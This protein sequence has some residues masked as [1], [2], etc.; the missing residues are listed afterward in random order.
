MEPG[1][2]RLTIDQLSRRTGVT[3]RNI[4]AYQTKGLLPAP[5][6]EGRVGVY[7]EGHMARLKLIASLQEKGY[8]LA[9]IGELLTAWET[10]Q[11]LGALL[12]FEEVLTTPWSDEEP[13]V[14]SPAAV[15]ELFPGLTTD[16]SLISAAEDAGLLAP[17]GQ[18]YLAPSRR[19][20][21]LG[22]ILVNTGMPL[23]DVLD[24]LDAMRQ[25][26]AT[27]ANRVVSRFVQ[28]IWEPFVAA[29]QPPDRLATI[30]E[31]IQKLRKLAPQAVAGVLSRAI[32]R[33]IT[34]ATIRDLQSRPRPAEA[35]PAS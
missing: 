9:A 1:R 20:L 5:H 17:H 29:G 26:L 2:I 22:S 33:E 19:L 15:E 23:P 6:L 35:P 34:S 7:D 14:L 25:D 32:E 11:D 16:R 3:S 12:G 31:A 24:N 8:S 13:E 4:R 18:D 21:Q 28:S 10:G 30:G 27:I